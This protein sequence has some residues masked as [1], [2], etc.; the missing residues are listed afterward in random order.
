MSLMDTPIITPSQMKCRKFGLKKDPLG[1]E[2]WLDLLCWESIVKIIVLYKLRVNKIH[3]FQISILFLPFCN[4]FQKITGI[5]LVSVNEFV[6]GEERIND[7]SAYEA[8]HS[9]LKDVLTSV[10]DQW[11]QRDIVHD[12]SKRKKLNN[13]KIKGHLEEAA[14]PYFYRPIDIS[15]IA[16]IRCK[17][18]NY[19][20]IFRKTPFF[21]ILANE[22]EPTHVQFYTTYFS[23]Y[24]KIINRDNYLYDELF[25][26]FYYSDRFYQISSMFGRWILIVLSTIIFT[27]SRRFFYRLSNSANINIGVEQLQSRVRLEEINDI[28]WFEQSQINPSSIYNLESHNLDRTSGQILEQMKINRAMPVQSP[29]PLLKSLLIDRKYVDSILFITATKTF[30][31]QT[32]WNM[33]ALLRNIF[34]WNESAWIRVQLTKYKYRMAYW[35][36]IYKQ[37]NIKILWSMSDVDTDKFA[38]LQALEML[39]GF[40]VGGH[41]S[42]YPM[43]RVDNQNTYDILFTWGP[44][45]VDNIMSPYPSLAKFIVGYP[46]TY[47]FSMQAKRAK[48]LRDRYA[49]KFIL[50]YQDNIMANDIPYS[51]NMQI[52]IHEMLLHILEEND[53][54]VLLLKPK[55]KFVFRKIKERIPRLKNL[56]KA[57][58]VVVFLGDTASTKEVP[59]TI[60]MASDLVIGLG[61][62]T[63]AAECHFAG[64]LAFHIDLTGFVNNEFGNKGLG[65]VVF[66]DIQSLY[67]AINEQIYK[68][69]VKKSS[70]YRKLYES[71]DPFQDGQAYRRTGSILKDLQELLNQ[72]LTRED[73][74]KTL[75]KRYND[76]VVS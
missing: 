43:L 53:D 17:Q 56:L 76:Y 46:C 59:A 37:L 42:N 60:G 15:I 31:Q 74:I 48:E 28:F 69:N 25:S 66:R 13:I 73:A 34:K 61:V 45:F 49:N 2:V 71:L 57:G 30:A 52:A 26:R 58:R 50:S 24:F 18:T 68:Y 8:V 3:F 7:L 14:F 11:I 36:N 41:W 38:K 75:C 64:T 67:E 16:A 72:G 10:S 47:Y 9:K 5:L 1:S 29:R 12:F 23:H 54:V 4:L 70:D 51:L 33:L 40:Y 35:Q 20:L 19:C 32:M 39:G 6:L 63:T 44:H 65:Q 27:F 21:D 55:R 22:L 62:S